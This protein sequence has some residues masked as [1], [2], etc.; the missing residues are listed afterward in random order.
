MP[1]NKPCFR[2]RLTVDLAPYLPPPRERAACMQPSSQLHRARRRCRQT[3]RTEAEATESASAA[4]HVRAPASFQLHRLSRR[5]FCPRVSRSP[6][7]LDRARSA[8]AKPRPFIPDDEALARAPPRNRPAAASSPP[9]A[10]F[11]TPPFGLGRGSRLMVHCR[12]DA[13]LATPGPWPKSPG[14][15]PLNAC[16]AALTQN[17]ANTSHTARS[18]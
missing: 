15:A 18:G 3:V 1:R 4:N 17:R 11:F 8:Q 5:H 14:S 12:H 13:A 6:P 7:C 2:A 9:V 10:P 16:G